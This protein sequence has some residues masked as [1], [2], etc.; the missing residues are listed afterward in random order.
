MLSRARAMIFL[1]MNEER[2]TRA[3]DRIERA[4]ARIETHRDQES[5]SALRAHLA[6]LERRHE[7]LRQR[8]SDAVARLTRLIDRAEGG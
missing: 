8:T 1:A 5:D 4:L 7:S 6:D 3:L 2:L